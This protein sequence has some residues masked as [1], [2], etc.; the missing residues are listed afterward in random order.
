M[1]G[2]HNRKAVAV[3]MVMVHRYLIPTTSDNDCN[4]TLIIYTV[5]DDHT[6]YVF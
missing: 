1:L 5:I 6:Y 2:T 4:D 3:S